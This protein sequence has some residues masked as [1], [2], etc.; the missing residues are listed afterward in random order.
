MAAQVAQPVI[1]APAIP[2][3]QPAPVGSTAA[4]GGVAVLVV[5][6]V[7]IGAVLY[8]RKR[9]N[10]GPRTGQ[11][12]KRIRIL[13]TQMLGPRAMLA[14]VEFGGREHLIAHTEHGVTRIADVEAGTHE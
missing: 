3:R 5:S 6:L 8:L 2:F 7:A 9:L 11:G 14:V 13:E 10:L 4:S 12:G 1:Q